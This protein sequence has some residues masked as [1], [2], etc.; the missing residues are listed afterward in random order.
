MKKI[1][2]CY[3]FCQIIFTNTIAQ[4]IW[5]NV[6]TKGMGYVDGLFIHP[7]TNTKFVRTDVGGMFRFNNE[8]QQWTNIF[9]GITKVGNSGINNVE[10]F[11]VDKNTSGTN[12]IIYAL[13]GGRK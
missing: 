3:L 7:T 8:T 9:D 13:S 5:K 11:A 4:T 6:S 10:A 12:Q 1:I 2:L